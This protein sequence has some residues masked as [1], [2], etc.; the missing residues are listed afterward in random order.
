LSSGRLLLPTSIARDP[1]NRAPGPY[2]GSLF[3]SDDDGLTWTETAG[4]V[5]LPMR[6]VME[7]HVEETRDGRVLMVMRNQLGSLFMSESADDGATWSVLA[8]HVVSTSISIDT[9]SMP[10]SREGRIRV[11]ATDGINTAYDISD[12]PFTVRNR[13]PNVEILAPNAGDVYLAGQTVS[14][15]AYV[16]DVDESFLEPGNV[17]WSSSRDGGIGQGTELSLASLTPG[18][19]TITLEAVDGAGARSSDSVHIQVYAAP[20]DLPLLPDTLQAEPAI[21]VL[22][23]LIGAD[24][25]TIYLH[26]YTNPTSIA[27]T[28]EASEPWVRL[29]ATKGTTPAEVTVWAD[30]GSLPNGY[31][32]AE[33]SF[34]N[35]DR[36]GETTTVSLAVTVQNSSSIYLPLILKMGP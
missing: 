22:N 33:V 8:S 36:H 14:L 10:A 34:A 5:V 1:E 20:G 13:R 21:V 12:G 16:H 29:G 28:A 18:R 11:L 25:Q 4:R 6:R 27:W 7:P 3:Y 19:H 30:T 9:A 35:A 23:P 17:T 15:Q 24:S 2:D 26:N 32:A 31:Y